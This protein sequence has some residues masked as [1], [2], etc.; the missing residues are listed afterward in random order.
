MSETAFEINFSLRSSDFDAQG[1]IKPSSVL[2][3]FQESATRHAEALGTGFDDMLAHKMFWVLT[4][5]R[6]TVHNPLCFQQNVKVLTR[7]YEPKL[8]EFRRDFAVYDTNG[9]LLITGTSMWTVISSETRRIVRTTGLY[10]KDVLSDEHFYDGEILRLP[11]FDGEK[12]TKTQTAEYCDLDRNGHVNNR[13][14]ADFAQNVLDFHGEIKNFQ[15]DFHREILAGDTVEFNFEKK[16]A[17]VLIRGVKDG[18]AMF[19]C[20][21]E[22]IK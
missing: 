16:D 17:S 4:K 6:Y 9:V 7:A 15:I 19:E 20:F 12:L 5:V 14:Y 11:D 8:V 10:G 13:R 1:R 2:D 3:I 22:Y 21:E 18:K